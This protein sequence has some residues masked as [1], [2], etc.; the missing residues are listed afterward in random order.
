MPNQ[1]DREEAQL[2]QAAK[3]GLSKMRR[4]ANADSKAAP[5]EN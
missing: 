1:N 5:A 2:S 4:R 3:M